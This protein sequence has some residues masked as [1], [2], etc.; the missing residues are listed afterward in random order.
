[1]LDM[2]ILGSF[3]NKGLQISTQQGL[4]H[5]NVYFKCSKIQRNSIENQL[6]KSDSALNAGQK[7]SKNYDNRMH[8]C[9]VITL[10]S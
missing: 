7:W 5:V 6:T 9:R 8:S 2:P 10:E 1:M 4:E 3:Q